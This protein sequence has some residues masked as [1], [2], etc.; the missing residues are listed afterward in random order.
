MVCLTSAPE[1]ALGVYQLDQIMGS[2]CWIEGEKKGCVCER[3][4]AREGAN[5]IT[6][7]IERER[8]R[9]EGR[10]KVCASEILFVPMCVFVYVRNW[11]IYREREIKRDDGYK[12]IEEGPDGRFDCTS[13]H[14]EKMVGVSPGM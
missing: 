10:V 1:R 2:I 3:K 9:E 14:R 5:E 6:R 11:G 4:R 8:G 12:A 7:E 13:T